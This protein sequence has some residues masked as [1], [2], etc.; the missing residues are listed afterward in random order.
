MGRTS[1][2]VKDEWNRKHYTPVKVAVKHETATGFKAACV[3]D[4]VSM[5]SVL[6][7]F[8]DGYANPTQEKKSA[9]VSVKTLR[10]RRKAMA[11]VCAL[12]TEMRDAEEA[13]MDRMPES[14]QNSSRYED[15]DERLGKLDEVFDAINDI[16]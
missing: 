11:M 10:D 3:A 15:A 9:L 14:L 1:N 16:Y 13:Y 8:M 4:G 7:D 12:I 6:S 5:A 2:A